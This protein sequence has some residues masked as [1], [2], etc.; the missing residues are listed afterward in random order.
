MG[1][2]Q[3]GQAKF[4][5][6]AL[7][8]LQHLPGGVGVKRRGGLVRQQHARRGGQRPGDADALF[9]AARQLG[10]IAA[11]LRGQADALDQLGHAGGDAGGFDAGDFQRQGDVFRDRAR[12]EQVEMLEY[13]PDLAP[14]GAQAGVRGRADIMAVD[15]DLARGGAFQPVHHAQQ[16]R[17]ACAGTADNAGDRALRHVQPDILQCHHIAARGLL[18]IAACHVLK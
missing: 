11:R 10:R 3:D 9:L 14:D 16:R 17:F 5:V 12:G 1:D 18:R 7:Q 6:D 4:A 8:K 13:H 15:D 2:Q